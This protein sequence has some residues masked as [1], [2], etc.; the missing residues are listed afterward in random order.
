MTKRLWRRATIENRSGDI[1][2]LSDDW[3]LYD[4]NGAQLA[5]IAKIRR[6]PPL[7]GKW[8]WTLFVDPNG[9]EASSAGI[10]DIGTEARERVEALIPPGCI[11]RGPREP[12]APP[13]IDPQLSLPL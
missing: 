1:I 3:I 7:G 2:P 4:A 10:E 13:P 8:T 6:G 5:R 12:L 11:H 9:F